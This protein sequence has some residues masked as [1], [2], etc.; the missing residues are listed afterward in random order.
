MIISYPHKKSKTTDLY[1][2]LDIL[3]VRNEDGT[4]KGKIYRKKTHT[5]QYWNNSSHDPI[6]QKA[7]VPTTL[8]DR[9]YALASKPEDIATENEKIETSL[10]KCCMYLTWMLNK[11]KQ[12]VHSK[13]TGYRQITKKEEKKKTIVIPY[14]KGISEAA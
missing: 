6:H 1:P 7:E 2:F 3:V 5:E 4:V 11:A 8:L 13:Y 14:I 10:N 12:Q 9:A